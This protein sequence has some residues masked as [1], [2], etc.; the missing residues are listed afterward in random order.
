MVGSKCNLKM[1]VQNLE[2]PL[3]YESGPKTTFLCGLRNLRA[4][5]TAFIFGMK[6]DIDNR[7]SALT[8]TSGL[9][10]RPKMS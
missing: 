4:I 7:S 1:R 3:P 8:T 9:L 5:L 6:D 10:H 2:H